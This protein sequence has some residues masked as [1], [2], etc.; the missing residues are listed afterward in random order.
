MAFDWK[1]Y[2]DLAEFLGTGGGQHYTQEAACRSAVSRSYYAAFCYARNFARDNHGFRPTSTPEDHELVRRHFRG[3][4]R[5]NVAQCLDALRQWRNDCD[6]RDT[7]PNI[8]I[9]TKP[10]VM[11]AHKVFNQ[12]DK[13]RI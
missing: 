1:E 6:Y 13:M 8:E 12:I 11:E 7:V 5:T 10:A 2:L 9:L 4:G 3:C